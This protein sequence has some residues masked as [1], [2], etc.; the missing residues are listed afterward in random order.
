MSRPAEFRA[1][2]LTR[3]MVE[4]DAEFLKGHS[5]GNLFRE[6]VKRA[7]RRTCIACGVHPGSLKYA[8]RTRQRGGGIVELRKARGLPTK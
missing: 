3:M 6:I 1:A 4:H 7:W 2:E 8:L 5:W